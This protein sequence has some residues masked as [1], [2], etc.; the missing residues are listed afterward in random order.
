MPAP[1]AASPAPSAPGPGAAPCP[2]SAVQRGTGRAQCA[3]APSGVGTQ[4][5]LAAT[6]CCLK[7]G[8]GGN[9]SVHMRWNETD[10]LL[11]I[12]FFSLTVYGK[13]FDI[14]KHCYIN[15]AH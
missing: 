13:S 8:G 4:A 1:A 9:R 15:L 14:H 6:G 5:S 11:G 2:G 7:P 10:S 3:C 12:I